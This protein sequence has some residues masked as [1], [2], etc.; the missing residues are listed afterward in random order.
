MYIYMMRI[1]RRIWPFMSEHLG[2]HLSDSEDERS[3]GEDIQRKDSLDSECSEHDDERSAE[4]QHAAEINVQ[5]MRGVSTT[6]LPDI[7]LS[8]S[9]ESIRKKCVVYVFEP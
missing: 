8:L 4:V 6:L 9:F 2:V 3:R 7:S 5:D 1:G